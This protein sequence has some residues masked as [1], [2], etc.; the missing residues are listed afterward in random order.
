M[1]FPSVSGMSSNQSFERTGLNRLVS[2][3]SPTAVLA[4]RSTQ[5]RYPAPVNL[6]ARCVFLL[7]IAILTTGA[8]PLIAGES[9]CFGTV[10]N[11]RIEGAVKL[12]T[13]GPCRIPGTQY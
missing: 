4:R 3:R 13:S 1:F 9:E 11:G 12:P 2:L 6:N 10:S 5:I 7:I 8:G